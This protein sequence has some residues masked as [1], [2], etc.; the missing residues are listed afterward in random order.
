[1]QVKHYVKDLLRDYKRW[2][3][4][5]LGEKTGELDL[6]QLLAEYNKILLENY[7]NYIANYFVDSLMPIH[8]FAARLT[9]EVKSV[10]PDYQ[11]LICT[12]VSG[13]GVKKAQFKC[14]VLPENVL[15]SL[16]IELKPKH[17]SN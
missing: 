9:K 2:G 3:K 6:L 5:K 12:E 4:S 7:G 16:N 17:L 11:L 13:D 10:K 1:M 8:A 15:R 14:S